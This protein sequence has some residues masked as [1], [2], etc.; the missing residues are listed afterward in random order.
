MPF[1]GAGI[2]YGAQ[3]GGSAL[4]KRYA[5]K[6]PPT[7]MLTDSILSDLGQ[8]PIRGN[9]SDWSRA[10][11][12]RIRAQSLPS[13]ADA[14]QL[15]IDL[16]PEKEA[17]LFAADGPLDIRIFLSLAPTSAHRYI[18]WL[19]REGLFSEVISTNYDCALE[20][21]YA[22]SFG[23]DSSQTAVSELEESK[24]RAFFVAI[25]NRDDY[26]NHANQSQSQRLNGI[27][28]TVLRLYKINGCAANYADL[29]E[30]DRKRRSGLLVITERH[31]QDFGLRKWAE[32]LFRDRFRCRAVVF[33][34]FG[35]E[36]PQVR[37]TALRVLEEFSDASAPTSP[38][39]S[40]EAARPPHCFVQE[41]NSTLTASQ[42]QIA[43]AAIRPPPISPDPLPAVFSKIGPN[44]FW[45]DLYRG[46]VPRVIARR[47]ERSLVFA[48]LREHDDKRRPVSL[49]IAHALR[50]KLFAEPE[51]P[52]PVISSWLGAFLS[53]DT[54]LLLMEL[55]W[56]ARQSGSTHG[57][58]PVGYYEEFDRVDSIPV[59]VLYVFHLL[60]IEASSVTL[61]P[62]NLGFWFRLPVAE[63]NNS[64]LPT[65]FRWVLVTEQ[66]PG[67]M[68][69]LPS[70]ESRVAVCLVLRKNGAEPDKRRPAAAH[71][72][73]VTWRVIP[74]ADLI[75]TAARSAPVASLPGQFPAAHFCRV[76]LNGDF[77][78]QRQSFYETQH[79][80]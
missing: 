65:L 30:E 14:A 57:A 26:R 34:G 4:P 21:A 1:L 72:L 20:N 47:L 33:S 53:G 36:E 13:F 31:L 19:V 46:V 22:A 43:K 75:A 39:V 7:K 69:E 58:T 9:M 54:T 35:A 18:A 63:P 67:R 42:L 45:R 38:A 3:L 23:E 25:S 56:R 5:D 62:C 40:Y 24:R 11:E 15:F 74:L 59:M 73:A 71:T 8:D 41:Y 78:N 2:S 76:L 70:G 79:S 10:E 49:A 37:F 50:K 28:T 60:G 51:A 6:M 68:P 12:T 61:G 32:D 27:P 55:V 44:E 64:E 16:H 48:W 17:G 77:S 80:S 29:T 52:A 66:E